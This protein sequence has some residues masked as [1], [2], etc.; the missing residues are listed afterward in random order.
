MGIYFRYGNYVWY[1]MRHFVV[2]LNF[3]YYIGYIAFAFLGYYNP[4]FS[5]ALLLDVFKRLIYFLYKILNC[6]LNNF[7]RGEA[8]R[9]TYNHFYYRYF[10]DLFFLFDCLFQPLLEICLRN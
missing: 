2:D 9:L 10:V 6:T 5:A 1:F 7:S 3:D 8:N 4:L